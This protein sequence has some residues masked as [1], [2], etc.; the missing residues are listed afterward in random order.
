MQ[1][2]PFPWE[3]PTIQEPSA[4]FRKVVAVISYRNDKE[5]GREIL[6][7]ELVWEAVPKIV[8]RGTKIPPTYIRPISGGRQS[9]GFGRRNAPSAPF[10]A[11]S[12]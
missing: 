12:N 5:T 11:K 6:K 3:P 4:G 10:A 9:S 2:P 1:P 8:E 7:E